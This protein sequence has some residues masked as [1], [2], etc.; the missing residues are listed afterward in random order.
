[1][2]VNSP[3][4]NS[5]NVW[6]PRLGVTY[7]F[8]PLDVVRGSW[9]EYAQPSSSAFQQYNN[10]EYNLPNVSPNT[11]FYG[12]GIFQPAHQIVPEISYNLDLSWEHQQKNSDLSW[13]L[14][15]F[16]RKTRDELYTVLLDPKT[17]FVS[18]INVGNLNASGAEFLIQKGDFSRNGLSGQLA[19]TYTYATVKFN[20]LPNGGTVLDGVNQSIV[21]YN[22]YTSYCANHPHSGLCSIAGQPVL[23]NNGAAAGACYG[24]GAS[25]SAPASVVPCSSKGAI[26]N[27]YWNATPQGLYD[28]GASYIAYNQLPGTG[29]SSVSSSYNIPWV[30]TLLMNY[31][32]DRWSVTP[33]LQM[34]AGGRY[35]SPVQGQGVDPISCAGSLPG[36]AAIDPRYQNGAVG[37][38]P[39]DASTCFGNIVTPNFQSGHFDNFG[40]FVEPTI[41]SLS[42]QSTY[43]VSNKL[44]LRLTAANLYN[45]CFGG[46]KAAWTSVPYQPQTGCWFGTGAAYIG[47]FYNPGDN[48]QQFIKNSYSPQFGNVFQLAYGGQSNPFQL[49]ITA[50][51][52]I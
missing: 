43:Q 13:K 4:S 48:V 28:T 31:K 51:M 29:V 46:T 30:S 2:S 24:P 1:V 38:H 5:Y 12:F 47:N 26:A 6:Q 8:D 25:S 18:A 23:P 22:A 11:A 9:G 36:S 52:K 21:H 16:L 32:H 44:T 14:T 3:R 10:A 40:A 50:E 20:G 37:G 39:Y 34:E 41:L 35:G 15:P 33:A 17:A 42:L 27:P 45:T 19:L 49:F 7:T